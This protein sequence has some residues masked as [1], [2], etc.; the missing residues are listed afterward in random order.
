[1]DILPFYSSESPAFLAYSAFC[2]WSLEFLDSC[3]TTSGL[4]LTPPVAPL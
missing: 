2:L 4:P 3:A 1:M